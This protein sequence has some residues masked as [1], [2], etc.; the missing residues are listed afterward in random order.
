MGYDTKACVHGF[1]SRQLVHADSNF[2]RRRERHHGAYSPST[3]TANPRVGTNGALW[4]ILA[5]ASAFR[6]RKLRDAPVS[7]AYNIGAVM[8]CSD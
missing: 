3:A 6:A 1:V 5:S 7:V 4:A 2:W 8:P